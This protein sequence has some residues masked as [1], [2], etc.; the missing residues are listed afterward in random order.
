MGVSAVRACRKHQSILS[1]LLHSSLRTGMYEHV[2][3][4]TAFSC[5]PLLVNNFLL[6]L[7][8]VRSSHPKPMP[9]G[10]IRSGRR[11]HCRL[12]CQNG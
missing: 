5:Q 9:F 7:L 8:L 3:L 12:S 4:K 6:S 11:G 10:A 2:D 1:D